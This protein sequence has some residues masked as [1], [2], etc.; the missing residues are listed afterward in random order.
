M[1]KEPSEEG[2]LKLKSYW[3]MKQKFP[4]NIWTEITEER[5][6][7][8]T[9]FK[10]ILKCLAPWC[11]RT[12]PTSA[13]SS[14][15]ALWVTRTRPLPKLY[16]GS[17]SKGWGQRGCRGRS[18]ETWMI[19]N[20]CI[21]WWNVILLYNCQRYLN[22]CSKFMASP[23]HRKVKKQNSKQTAGIFW[24]GECT[25]NSYA[26]PIQFWFVRS[27]FNYSIPAECL[28]GDPYFPLFQICY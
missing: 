5:R 23:F 21:T 24:G 14:L 11:R 4:L 28:R 8:L 22:V 10:I 27:H 13:H 17:R 9:E 12:L 19:D 7:M 2:N 26:H 3:K 16:G 1:S 15:P 6:K 18:S 20:K 25:E